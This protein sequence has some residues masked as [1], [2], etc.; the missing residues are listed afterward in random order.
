MKVTAKY[1]WYSTDMR[2]RTKASVFCEQY[3]SRKERLS[4]LMIH[5]IIP[6]LYFEFYQV[7]GVLA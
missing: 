5:C 1:G 4:T 6:Y 3:K 2:K 7:T